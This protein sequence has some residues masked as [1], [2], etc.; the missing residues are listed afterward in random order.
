MLQE[1]D[2]AQGTLR[3]D[4]LA[5]DIGDFLDRDTF[6][7]LGILRGAEGGNV[8]TLAR[9]GMAARGLSAYQTMP[10]AP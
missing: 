10:Y 8:S 7:R 3:E 9:P 5:E 6:A 2:L 4:F 1:L